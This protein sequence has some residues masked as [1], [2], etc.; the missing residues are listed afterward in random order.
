MK[1]TLLCFFLKPGCCTGEEEEISSWYKMNQFTFSEDTRALLWCAR[2]EGAQRIKE[3]P[4]MGGKAVIVGSRWGLAASTP[5]SPLEPRISSAVRAP[6]PSPTPGVGSSGFRGVQFT[7]YSGQI[8][9]PIAGYGARSGAE[10]G[11]PHLQR[12]EG[13][14]HWSHDWATGRALNLREEGKLEETDL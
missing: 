1:I 5:S 10:R 7:L 14:P 4:G 9:P 2:P 11:S 8:A 12:E 6:P 13:G 3:G